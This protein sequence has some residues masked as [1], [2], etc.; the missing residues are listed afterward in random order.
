[1]KKLSNSRSAFTLIELLVVIAIIAI[2]AGIAMPAF[3]GAMRRAHV[4]T[5]SNSLRQMGTAVNVYLADNDDQMITG[6]ATWVASTNGIDGFLGKYLGA[7]PKALQCPFDK[8]SGTGG[9]SPVSLSFNKE[10]LT[11]STPPSDRSKWDGN[12]SRLK[13][14]SNTILGAPFY[15]G[16]PSEKSSWLSVLSSV[17]SIPS[18]GGD[19]GGPKNYGLSGSLIPVVRCDVSIVMM[20][21]G[22]SITGTETDDNFRNEKNWKPLD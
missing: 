16:D 14:P 12:W 4:T 18:G 21:I 19:I 3:N 6:D 11:P 1:M 8:R 2:L 13:R 5:T 9:N 7:N 17:N 20:R 15:V 22:K 10:I